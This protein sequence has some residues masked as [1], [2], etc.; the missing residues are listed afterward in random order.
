MRRSNHSLKT[1]SLVVALAGS[2]LATAPAHAAP[3][4]P[5]GLQALPAGDTDINLTWEDTADNET[6]FRVDAR[7]AGGTFASIGTVPANTEA[8]EITNLAPGLRYEFRVSS[9]NGSTQSGFSNIASAYT[10][11]ETTPSGVCS[12]GNGACLNDRFRVTGTWRTATDSGNA[13]AHPIT[14]QSSAFYFFSPDNLELLVKLV[15]GCGLNDRYWLFFAATTNVEFTLTVTD[16]ET[17]T[18]RKY[19]NPLNRAALPVQ[20]TSAF[21][22]CP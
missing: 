17:G 13:V 19:F 16:T 5:A 3:G 7:V 4:R 10:D 1:L 14:A 20:D 18:V 15:N 11:S 6:G 12:P 2:G 22:T 21:A 8:A 9:F